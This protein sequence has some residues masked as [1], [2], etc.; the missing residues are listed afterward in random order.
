MASPLFGVVQTTS[1]M[2]SSSPSDWLLHGNWVLFWIV[3]Y[4]LLAI[5]LLLATLAT[6]DRCLGRITLRSP[7]ASSPITGMALGSE[8]G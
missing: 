2:V 6:F 8:P 3:A 5:A 4:C 7:A 1:D